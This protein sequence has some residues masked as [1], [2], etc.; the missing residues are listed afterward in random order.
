MS[1]VSREI[2]GL[3]RFLR[4]GQWV[5]RQVVVRSLTMA[6]RGGIGAAIAAGL[7]EARPE[8]TGK[9]GPV[10]QMLRITEAGIAVLAVVG[11]VDL[12][13]GYAERP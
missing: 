11:P 2:K 5:A 4:P 6:D 10:T 1:G 12:P 3:L 9:R 8:R 13:T 7:V